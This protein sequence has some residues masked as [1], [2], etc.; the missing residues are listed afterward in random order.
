MRVV[1]FRVFGGSEV[2]EVADAVLPQPHRGEIAVDVRYAG[3]NFADIMLR[4]GAL[5]GTPLPTV[6][7]LEVAGTVAEIGP[8]VSGFAY[9]E[10]V[11]AFSWTPGK[12]MG[13][14]AQ[15]VVLDSRLAVPL[16]R[17][18]RELR[19]EEG[20]GFAC[21]AVTAYQLLAD[22]A[23]LRPGETVLVQSAAGGVG[24]LAV[25][26]ARAL[27]AARIFGVVGSASKTEAALAAGCDR[28][29]LREGWIEA[30]RSFT[31]GRGVD[32]ALESVGGDSLAACLQ[33]LAPFGRVAYFGDASGSGPISLPAFDLWF[34]TKGVLGYNIGG[35]AAASPESWNGAAN[36]AIELIANGAVRLAPTRI[37][38]LERA[39]EAQHAL[40]TRASTGK[41]LLQVTS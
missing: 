34:G 18:E 23:R 1:Q 37:Y 26:F 27:G 2:L 40:E 21:A 19:Y 25:Q 5:A 15:R 36:R 7:G 38:P 3:V 31:G 16:R 29:V 33:V 12:A 35:L 24:S 13:G 39:A 6:P 10:P 11:A 32:I 4:R 41:M 20:A 17:A 9:G 8:G 28:V 14:Y 22:V 30:V